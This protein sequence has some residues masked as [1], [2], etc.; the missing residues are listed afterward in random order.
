MKL[1]PLLPLLLLLLV[2]TRAPAQEPDL[3]VVSPSDLPTGTERDGRLEAAEVRRVRL[4][5]EAFGGALRVVELHPALREG[6]KVEAGATLARLDPAP[7]ERE[8]RG[9]REALEAA[10]A[11][12]A[13][14]QAEHQV[15]LAA[16][17]DALEQA[18]AAARDAD[19]AL[20]RFQALD[21]PLLLDGAR[22]SVERS[23]H[24]VAD[25]REELEQLE[26]MY[27]GTRLAPETKEIVLERAR[28]N[29]R[30]AERGLDQTRRGA[31]VTTAWEHPDRLRALE[32]R[33][34][35]AAAELE[36]LQERQRLEGERRAV[37]LAAAERALRD[38]S[39]RVA[40]LEA[41]L[42]K[43]TVTAPL[44][45][46]VEASE[47]RP[48]DRV[49]AG[50]AITTVHDT[51]R[52][53]VRFDATEDDLR[54]LA[55]GSKVKLRLL[56][57]GEVTLGGAVLAVAE[58]P[59]REQDAPTYPVVVQVDKTHPR[60]RVG[61][62][63][64]VQ[65]QGELVRRA[66]VVPRRALTIEGGRATCQVWANGRATPIEVILGPGNQ[67]S[68]QV[69]RGLVAGDAVVLPEVE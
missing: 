47:L 46:V 11:D 25:Q 50:Q 13:H 57:F 34:R 65:A 32:E 63:V 12:L 9:A 27:D 7:L 14:G 21:G 56:A 18:Q 40:E 38:A 36:Q 49:A 1:A 30:H 15:A 52:L 8:L 5:L 28:R 6:G 4:D 66:L 61:L 31:E 43:L 42:A 67:E 19:R 54:L 23:E 35:W 2:P 10:K 69:L 33:A 45:G 68:V 26:G 24:H 3:H 51:S 48:G 17:K 37:R 58:V 60:A 62:R 44:G 64:R 41:D 16:A 39:E 55:P 22:H 29:L 53:L 20:E 59:S